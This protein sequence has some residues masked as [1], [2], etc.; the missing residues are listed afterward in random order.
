MRWSTSDGD[1]IA[2]SDTGVAE[3]TVVHA[4]TVEATADLNGKTINSHVFFAEPLVPPP[5][6]N[7]ATNVP[8][9]TFNWTS[10]VL[11]V[12]CKCNRSVSAWLV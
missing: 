12:E 2:S 9:Y 3:R 7:N 10:S 8:D 11:M 4:V 6:V 1:V 5:G